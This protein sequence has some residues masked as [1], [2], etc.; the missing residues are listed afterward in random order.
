[1]RVREW[2]GWHFPEVGKIVTDNIQYAKM[3]LKM[4]ETLTY[5]FCEGLTVVSTGVR[6][7]ASETDLSDIL[8]EETD[9][10]VKQ[11]AEVSMGT[12][13]AD[14]DINNMQALCTQ[15]T[16]TAHESTKVC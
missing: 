9:Q 4:G 11:A 1:M 6:T 5:V 8:E 7:N 15:V 14:E 16:I 3:V 10:A 2:Y 12:E 13:V